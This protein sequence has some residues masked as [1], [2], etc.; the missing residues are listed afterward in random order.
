MTPASSLRW[1]TGSG[2]EEL[3]HLRGRDAIA[4]SVK[5]LVNDLRD[6]SSLRIAVVNIPARTHPHQV[7][8]AIQQTAQDM[9]RTRP[10]PRSP[11]IWRRCVC[12]CSLAGAVGGR[13]NQRACLVRARLA[14]D[15]A[16]NPLRS[17][18]A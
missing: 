16:T 8:D 2:D 6:R 3:E 4:G 12:R 17:I 10:G 18:S 11:T 1:N 14:C 13:C 15:L 9:A 5:R 7:D